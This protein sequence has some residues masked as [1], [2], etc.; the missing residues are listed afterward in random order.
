[1][2]AT[3]DK[4]RYAIEWGIPS[5]PKW[6]SNGRRSKYPFDS[7]AVGDS[8]FI[9]AERSRKEYSRYGSTVGAATKRLNRKFTIRQ[10]DGGFR[11]WRT[12]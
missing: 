7:M 11:V 6:A 10:V 9:S 1:M 4:P 2:P 5:P 12:A 3:P 8:F